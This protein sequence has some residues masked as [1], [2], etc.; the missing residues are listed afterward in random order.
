[1]QYQLNVTKP[2]F[3][4]GEY[5]DLKEFFDKLAESNNVTITIKKA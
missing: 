4:V 2:F 5:H 1:M 3:T